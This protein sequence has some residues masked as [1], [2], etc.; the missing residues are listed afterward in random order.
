MMLDAITV[1]I[2]SSKT[3]KADDKEAKAYNWVLLASVLLV[4]FLIVQT[5][6]RIIANFLPNGARAMLQSWGGTIW[7]GQVNGQYQSILG[8]VRWQF[9]PLALLKLKLGIKLELITNASEFSGRLQWRG[10][11]W[12]LLDANG[13]IASLE[14]QQFLSGWQLPNAPIEIK[15]LNLSYAN[16]EWQAAK[17]G[18]MWQGGALDY[19]LEGQRQHINLPAVSVLVK[20]DQKNL[21]LVLKDAQQD[22]NL[23]TFIV[24]GSVLESRL[25]QRLL[26]YAPSYRGV[27]EPDA[28][29][30]TSTQPLSSL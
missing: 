12:Q 8:Q 9:E 13:Q 3:T 6:A 14:L 19:V 10:N 1:K 20:N 21:E 17:G 4:I 2:M 30:V 28:I 18:I 15:N 29:V 11:S 27:A 7:S 24:R 5:P 22:A 26:S 16:Q 25:T 23:A